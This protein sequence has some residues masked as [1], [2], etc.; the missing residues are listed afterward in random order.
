MA[1]GKTIEGFMAAAVTP[2]NEAGDL[3]GDA[4][5]Q[6]VDWLLAKKADGLCIAGN[7]GENWALESDDRRT[8]AEIAMKRVA[9]RVPV[10]MGVGATTA[11]Q[12]ICY[13]EIAAEAGCDAMMLSP[14][15]YVGKATLAEVV[16]RFAAVHKAV[17]LPVLVF[18]SPR[19]TGIDIT[20]DMLAAICDAV[21]VVAL[22]ES[23]RDL[24]HTTEIVRRFGERLSVMIGPGYFIFPGLAMGAKGFISTGPESM[25]MDAHRFR[26]L[27]TAAPTAESRRIQFAINSLY[28]AL[29]NSGTAPAGLKAA[30]NMLGVPAGVPREPLKALGPRE[31]ERVRAALVEHG[32]LD[33]DR[34]TARAGE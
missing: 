24:H 28:P 13:A 17:P 19:Y 7:N 11:R 33:G 14:Q 34:K 4:F 31:V 18:N 30:L 3:M 32:Y 15:P 26:A 1:S 22:K 16:E 5:A 23:S 9:G 2:F 29:M 20:P 27:A 21:P 6:V 25:G 10:V 12:S 8:I